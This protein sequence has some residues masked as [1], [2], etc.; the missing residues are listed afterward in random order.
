MFTTCILLVQHITRKHW[1][2]QAR[3][4]RERNLCR[5]FAALIHVVLLRVPVR[6]LRVMTIVDLWPST[7]PRLTGV[8]QTFSVLAQ[9]GGGGLLAE[10]LRV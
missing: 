5:G 6:F 1:L 7:G 2:V 4:R 3:D 8:F 9:G 10:L